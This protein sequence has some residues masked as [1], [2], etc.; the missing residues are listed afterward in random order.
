MTAVVEVPDKFSATEAWQII[1]CLDNDFH[2]LKPH[3][4]SLYGVNRCPA[5][6]LLVED[7]V[8]FADGASRH[9]H[10]C[11]KHA[12]AYYRKLLEDHARI[13]ALWAVRAALRDW[14]DTHDPVL[15]MLQAWFPDVR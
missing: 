7:A 9:R 3:F 11:D 13:S 10:I 5:W 8:Y 6:A 12:A 14:S 4:R 2:T 1:A 15:A